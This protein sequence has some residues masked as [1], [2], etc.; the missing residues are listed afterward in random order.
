MTDFQQQ[1]EVKKI[2]YSKITI[3]VL[4]IVVIF[5][6]HSTYGIYQK[7]NLSATSYSEVK[8]EYDSLQERQSMLNSEIMRLKTENGIE[9]EI[10]SKFSVAKPGETVVVVVDE[11]GSASTSDNKSPESLWSKFIGLFQ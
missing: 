4:F 3:F 11:N 10:R 8:K 5:L 2:I 7:E 1:R 9:E 6:A